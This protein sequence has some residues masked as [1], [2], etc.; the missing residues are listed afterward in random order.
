MRVVEPC[1]GAGL[2]PQPVEP[3][4]AA[5][6]GPHPLEHDVPAQLLV[7]GHPYLAHAAADGSLRK[8]VAPTDFCTQAHRVSPHL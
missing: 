3:G 2:G 5:V 4:D 7:M 8:S 6:V 1:Q